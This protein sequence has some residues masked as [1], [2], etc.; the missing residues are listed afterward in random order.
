M[1]LISL[2]KKL[3]SYINKLNSYTIFITKTKDVN[4]LNEYYMKRNNN[5]ISNDE[6]YINL[7]KNLCNKFAEEFFNYL[8]VLHNLPDK[9][10]N[11]N[12]LIDINEKKLSIKNIVSKIKDIE[13][14]KI[15]RK[16]YSL[17]SSQIIFK[18]K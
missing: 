16:N 9:K 11:I 8:A 1:I 6:I 10:F 15:K 3:Y 13:G 14:N 2:K 4:L 5:K 17:S 7:D 18:K 12:E